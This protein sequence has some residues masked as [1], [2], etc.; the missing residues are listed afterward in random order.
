MHKGL[1]HVLHGYAGRW[2]ACKR[3][4]LRRARSSTATL[5]PYTS[6]E[7]PAY[8]STAPTCLHGS[9][10]ARI[11]RAAPRLRTQL[12]GQKQTTAH[13]GRSPVYPPPPSPLSL[14]L[15]AAAGPALAPPAVPRGRAVPLINMKAAAAAANG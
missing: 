8:S 4:S 10:G 11:V 13:N 5:S 9:A 1:L 6:V 14:P 7:H 12:A 3:C 2:G 15:R